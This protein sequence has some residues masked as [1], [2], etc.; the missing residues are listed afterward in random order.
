MD[1]PILGKV[2][3]GDCGSW[4]VDAITGDVYG[5]IVTTSRDN[6]NAHI[7]PAH[8]VFE[9]LRVRFSHTGLPSI[10]SRASTSTLD[11]SSEYLSSFPPPRS[12]RSTLLGSTHAPYAEMSATHTSEQLQNFLHYLTCD[13]CRKP[14]RI[15]NAR[16]CTFCGGKGASAGHF[17]HITCSVEG[18][19]QANCTEHTT[20]WADH[21]PIHPNIA[22][23]YKMVEPF[24][25]L[26]AK[27]VIESEERYGAERAS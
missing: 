1:C 5:H 6:G 19:A 22:H 2:V 10:A 15:Q 18:C 13:V 16:Q 24:A 25:L 11:T 20:C 14:V 17:Y 8:L 21:L 4:V 7:T 23:R 9:N 27:A 12:L 26:F 3:D